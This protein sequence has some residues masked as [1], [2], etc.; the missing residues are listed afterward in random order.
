MPKQFSYSRSPQER[1]RYSFP[2]HP[3]SMWPANPPGLHG[4]DTR[5]KME[6]RTSGTLGGQA[7]GDH[8]S[9]V[10]P[11]HRAHPLRSH[12]TH[13]PDNNTT[14][15][16]VDDYGNVDDD[17]FNAEPVAGLRPQCLLPPNQL[18]LSPE[19]HSRSRVFSIDGGSL[20]HH[21]RHLAT[22]QSKI[23]TKLAK[24][25][26]VCDHATSYSCGWRVDKGRK[27][28]IPINYDDCADHF[29][30]F[31]DIKDMAWNVEVIC[32]WCPS[33][34][35]KKVIRKNLLRHLREAHLCYPRSEKGI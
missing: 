23:P 8:P 5:S 14:G 4:R 15:G 32:C 29:A 34:L 33:K 30:A 16:G 6:L 20:L 31:H 26:T 3:Y 22:A 18:P 13:I 35:R 21:T 25:R 1:L 17:K 19:L 28:G 27:C 9:R 2:V 11:Y 10:F 24:A 12:A 7:L